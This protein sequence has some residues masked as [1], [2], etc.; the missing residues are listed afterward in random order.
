MMLF[1]C[2]PLT[3]VVFLLF[4]FLKVYAFMHY[5]CIMCGVPTQSGESFVVWVPLSSRHS[6]YSLSFISSQYQ[7]DLA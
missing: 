3:T 5:I 6:F 7:F 2:R 4:V 1:F